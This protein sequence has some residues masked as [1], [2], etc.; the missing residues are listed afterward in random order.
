M[1]ELAIKCLG[2][3]YYEAVR[4]KICYARQKIASKTSALDMG[5]ADFGLL[6][7]LIGKVP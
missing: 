5:R 1:D 3:S 2:H 4:F 7:E 6:R